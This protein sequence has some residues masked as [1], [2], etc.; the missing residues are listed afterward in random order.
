VLY[1][2]FSVRIPSLIPS[3]PEI[4]R[5]VVVESLESLADRRDPEQT[6]AAADLRRRN[7]RL[8][9]LYR[10]QLSVAASRFR[11]HSAFICNV[12]QQVL[13]MDTQTS[14]LNSEVDAVASM[15]PWPV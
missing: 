1:V 4:D 5:R 8:S 15:W 11:H 13:H 3:P 10:V 6:I 12:S 2:T 7:L 14:F 9:L